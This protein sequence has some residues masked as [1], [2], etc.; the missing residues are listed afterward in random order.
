MK[1][2]RKFEI[3]TTEV[4]QPQDTVIQE[5]VLSSAGAPTESEVGTLWPTAVQLEASIGALCPG[6]RSPG[7]EVG[8]PPDRQVRE[9]TPRD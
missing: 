4:G 2:Y 1:H 5:D 3:T 9:S 6:A 8:V 7:T